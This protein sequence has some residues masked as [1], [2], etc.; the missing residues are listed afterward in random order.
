MENLM[1]L[2]ILVLLFISH[3]ARGIFMKLGQ[4]GRVSTLKQALVYTT[5]YSALQAAVLLAVPPYP[6]LVCD[7]GFYIY[8][9]AFAVFYTLSYMM[10]IMAM[11]EGSTAIT[12]TIYSFNSLIPVLFGIIVWKEELSLCKGLGLLLFIAG[13]LLYNRSS[14]TVGGVKQK[15]SKKW[16]IYSLGTL[17]FM[18]IAVIFTKSSM[19]AFPNYGEQYLIFYSLFS[20]VLGGIFILFFAR[21]EIKPLVTDFKFLIFT[22]IAA[23]GLDLSNYIFVMFINKFPSA[24]FLPLCSV[25]GMIAVLVCGRIFLKEKISRSAC[26]SSFICIAAI[27]LLNF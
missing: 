2:V 27:V 7:V 23:V 4:K 9:F 8:P 26:V 22:G 12:N 24:F 5:V 20:F 21:E 13:L 15:I 18:G 6:S 11:N 3:G 14:Y 10:M 1:M 19:R 16:L 17:V 25:V